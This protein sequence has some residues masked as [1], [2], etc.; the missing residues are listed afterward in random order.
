MKKVLIF[1]LLFLATLFAKP[2]LWAQNFDNRK[3]TTLSLDSITI[4]LDSLS[5]IPNSLQILY[6]IAADQFELDCITAT[7]TLTD[8]SVLGGRAAFSYRVFHL[9]LAESYQH[10]STD[11]ILHN[12][13]HHEPRPIPI[14]TF[15]EFMRDDASFVSAGS[16]SRGFSMGN[17]QDL[18]LN[19]T[20][21]LQLSGMLS[22]DLEVNANI[23]D[24]NIPIQPDGNTMMIQ[25]FDRIFINLNYKNQYFLDAGDIDVHGRKS[26]FMVLNKR[27]LGMDL[28][29]QSH[30]DS[31]N[32]LFNQIGGGVNKGKFIRQQINII[33]GVQGPYKLYGEQNELNIIILSG[34]ERVYLDGRLLARGA[35]QDY[36]MDYNSGEITFT[37][38][39][40]MTS[41]KRINIEF[42]YK[43]DYFS[44][45]SLFTVNE[46]THEKNNK[47]KL[48]VN[49]YHDQDQK[50]R[51]IQPEL[52]NDQKSF[53]S[54]IGDNLHDAFYPVAD[55]VP[56][57]INEILY[58][59]SDTTVDGARYEPIYIHSTNSNETLYRLSFSLVGEQ[60]GNY[61]L[62]NNTANGRVFRWV[63]PVGGVPQGNYEPVTRL[64]TPKL[65]QLGTISAEYT[66]KEN[67]WIKG[68]MAVSNHDQNTFSSIDD[69]ENVGFAIKL[70]AFNKSKVFAKKREGW[71]WEN[72]LNYEFLSKNFHISE[73][74]REIEFAR[75]FNLS[76]DYTNLYS[77][78]LAQLSTKLLKEKTG[79]IEYAL[80]F[81][82]R[83]SNTTIFKN[84]LN[85]DF[86]KNG[87]LIVGNNSF[88]NG[89]DSLQNSK[90][91]QTNQQI[92]QS[93]KH[94][95][96]GITD[97][98]EINIFKQNRNDSL[99]GSSYAF[100]EAYL[101]IKNSDSLPYLFNMGYM[102]RLEYSPE[103][104][105]L[106]LQK[107]HNEIRASFEINK[108]KNNRIKGNITYRNSQIADS[109]QRFKGENFLTGSLEYTGRFAKNSIILSTFYEMGSGLEQKRTF[110]YLRVAD[111]QGT[112]TWNDY[113]GNGI[114]ELDEFEIAA[115]QDQAHYIKIWTNTA[116]YITTTNNR[117]TQTVQLQPRN[118]WNEKKGVLK[119]ISRFSNIASF[120]SAQKNTVENSLAAYN[121]FH[122]SLDDSLLINSNINFFN[123]LSFNQL[124]KFW[125][126]DYLAKI[127]QD[128][129]LFYYGFEQ[130]KTHS[131]EIILRIAP[132]KKVL[133]RLNYYNSH[134][135]SN[136][137]YLANKA[138][139]IEQNQAKGYLQYTHNNAIYTY[140]S[141]TYK[142][143][144]NLLGNERL[145]Q[146][147]LEININYRIAN[148]ANLTGLITWNSIKYNALDNSSISY[149]MLE[150][151]K[152]GQNL[153]WTLGG[154]SSITDFLQIELSYSGRASEGNKTIHLANIQLRAH[155]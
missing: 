77:E 146:H 67:S 116:E 82:S 46:F 86:K 80:N 89:K 53:L 60:N 50:N 40:L 10:K 63:A 41:E 154:Q 44:H 125:G 12:I 124:G 155:F 102:N 112:H 42:Q 83:P 95:V 153:S 133:L 140:V 21:N 97:I 147:Q 98:A 106:A 141:Y 128:K 123:N 74:F 114:E 8:S 115:F 75:N 54:N 59:K 105:R 9:N 94:L 4:K 69:E 151:L 111:G 61:V 57:N 47:L 16:I 49:F 66:L 56:Y 119:F 6:G 121:P 39:I 99:I 148:R 152:N 100:N 130:N 88:L 64:S 81:F 134:K 2:D 117:F 78:H 34:S 35:D 52:N 132:H 29:G 73:S 11:I 43:S 37:S 27:L 122:F 109:S 84:Y 17:N 104:D 107:M 65:V 110:S 120:Q 76:E 149:E 5:I 113:N 91:F 101:F 87:F 7:I 90:F 135:K 32:K 145:Y 13:V 139:H 92:A 33:N 28:Y 30:I 142:T 22:E 14:T 31:A 15:S 127:A 18:V 36:I 48:G 126:I 93:F 58:R 23:T 19:S 144:E 1:A 70:A 129:N 150:G 138:Y 131:H 3:T 51:S 45:Y 136:S 55:S 137:E 25:D 85:Y 26:H 79:H 20:L 62:E 71:H 96:F 108:L 72:S 38:K 103:N 143:K 24:R 68:E 118:V